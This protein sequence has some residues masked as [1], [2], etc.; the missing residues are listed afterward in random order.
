[1]TGTYT[2]GDLVADFLHAL[3]VETVF[4]IVSVHNIPMLDAIGRGNAI[5]FVMARGEMGGAHMADAYARV[6]G[7][8]GV[9]FT[10]TGP[11][12]ANAVPGLV[13]ARFGGA[14]LLH[15]TGQ[16][17]TADIDTGHGAVHDVPDQLGM[18]ASV[19]KKAFRVRSAEEALGTLIEA[20][21][22]ALTPP[23]GPVS[24]EIPIDIQR[25]RIDRPAD[26]EGLVLPIP[27][28]WAGD[29]GSLDRLAD[30][31]A[32]AKRP[33][34]WCGNGARHARAAVERLADMGVAVV[35]SGAGR[36]VIPETHP[37]MLGAFH[38][39][40]V[41][42]AFYET[43]DMMVVAGGRLRGHETRDLS[44]KL[45]AARVQIDIDP[46]A[47]GRTYTTDLFHTGEAG[48]ALSA[49]AD[50]LEGRL[51]VEDGYR[52]EIA[53]LKTRIV[54]TFRDTLGPYRDVP[55]AFTR[56]MG[57]DALW[58]RDVTLN[59]TTWGNRLLPLKEPGQ[60]VY[61]IGAAIG[62][63][64]AM[65]IGAA[66]AAEGR[67]TVVMTGDGG[68]FLNVGELWTAVQ[69]NVQVAIV[70]MN[71]KGYG[72][73]KHIQD[74]LYGGRHFFGD[75]KAPS[76]EGLAELA[77]IPFGRVSA[78]DQ[79]EGALRQAL[80]HPGPTLV[81]VDMTAIGPYPPYYKPPPYA[82]KG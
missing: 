14:P 45:P 78:V 61:P 30:A 43:V 76:L 31:V 72:V 44:M 75:L 71:D 48:A 49:L 40:P 18:L 58:V 3:G 63:G 9:L 19:S 5:R 66:F 79:L 28:A 68:F 55:D 38:A 52:A 2:V 20:A 24:V 17:Q 81:E 15:V 60:N 13:E 62:P 29:A 42:E 21:T 8:L 53:D 77:G 46:A 41:V 59:N 73:I 74:A 32:G 57:P 23:M 80:D 7:R 67:K 69:E 51:A 33:L 34:L 4:G 50:R 35:T 16:T 82:Q 36:A 26:L 12:A 25:T 64:L 6:S 22:A 70:V 47:R 56:A 54:E 11:G 65:G 10:S 39:G 1:M 27:P 37:M